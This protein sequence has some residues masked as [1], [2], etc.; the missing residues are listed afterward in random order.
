MKTIK[1]YFILSNGTISPDYDH[2]CYDG[3]NLSGACIY[4]ITHCNLILD[5]SENLKNTAFFW[6]FFILVNPPLQ[7]S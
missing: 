5:L 3:S 1:A 2:V 6:T 4:I 7:L